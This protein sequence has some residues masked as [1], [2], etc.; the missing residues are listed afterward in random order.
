MGSD[1]SQH[2]QLIRSRRIRVFTPQR[3]GVQEKH[4]DTTTRLELLRLVRAWVS[5][6]LALL[7]EKGFHSIAAV[8]ARKSRLLATPGGRRPGA[9][10]RRLAKRTQKQEP[11][12]PSPIRTTRGPPPTAQHTAGGGGGGAGTPPTASPA[13]SE[14]VDEDVPTA[15]PGVCL[16]RQLHA[17]RRPVPSA[18]PCCNASSGVPIAIA[19]AILRGRL[20]SS[21]LV[22]RRAVGALQHDLTSCLMRAQC[23]RGAC[24][25]RA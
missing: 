10:R 3:R 14:E 7:S 9:T 4:Y 1:S 24:H 11:S 6:S 23:T 25:A 17:A 15:Y 5:A 8:R 22:W 18:A 20:P 16:A 13:G 2:P 21:L 12:A 19:F